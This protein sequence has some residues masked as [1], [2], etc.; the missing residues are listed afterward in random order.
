MMTNNPQILDKGGYWLIF[1][2]VPP[3][4]IRWQWSCTVW[5]KGKDHGGISHF[6]KT[7]ADGEAWAATFM[8]TKPAPIVE[9][10]S[11]E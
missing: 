7:V 1:M 6:V 10:G 11:D 2:P 3:D 9:G 8:I 4:T 5:I